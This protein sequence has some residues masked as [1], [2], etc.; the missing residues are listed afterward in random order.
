MSSKLAMRVLESDLPR[1]LKATATTLALFANDEGLRIYPS[2]ARVAWLVGKSASRV[3]DDLSALCRLGVLVPLTARAGGRG[4]A[5]EYHLDVSALPSRPPFKSKPHRGREGFASVNPTAD[6]MVSDAECPGPNQ[7]STSQTVETPA[8][9]PETPTLVS[10][11]PHAHEVPA[12]RELSRESSVQQQVRPTLGLKDRIKQEATRVLA[13][14]P[15]RTNSCRTSRT[16]R[17][18][19]FERCNSPQDTDW[20]DSACSA[21][22]LGNRSG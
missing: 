9:A 11:N 12:L 19:C 18:V 5:T 17:V 7:E 1:H 6:A 21:L 20:T 3:T 4:R 14:S 2:V 16:S 15:V 13:A 10:E 22:V 8:L